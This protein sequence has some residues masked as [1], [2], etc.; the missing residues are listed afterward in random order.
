VPLFIVF[1]IG[2]W[3]FAWGAPDILAWAFPLYLGLYIAWPYEQGTRFLM[4]MLPVIWGSLWF[5][6]APWERFRRPVFAGLLVA[7][8][9]AALVYWAGDIRQ[10][11]EL[12]SYWPKLD[13]LAAAAQTEAGSGVICAD[14]HVACM[15]LLALNRAWTIVDK[16]AVM[17]PDARWLLIGDDRGDTPGFTLRLR[18]GDLRLMERAS[19]GLSTEKS[20]V[21]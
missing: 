1:A 8:L 13:R 5:F 18:V 12:A 21:K 17:D 15:F 19:G 14:R 20:A 9:L 4:P 3:R 6:A 2:W 7:G 10:E 16:A 11:R